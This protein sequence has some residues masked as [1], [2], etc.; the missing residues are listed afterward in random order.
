MS[1]DFLHTVGSKASVFHGYS[2]HTAGGLTKADLMKNSHG[3]IVS[4]RQHASG[5]RAFARLSP[6]AK[7]KW[8]K[9]CAAVASGRKPS[10]LRKS[11]SKKASKSRSK[12]A[13][14]SRSSRR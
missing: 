14:K 2:K 12:K 3:R 13:S 6:A 4:K 10:K 7:A 1:G 8:K 9:N 5:K 11:R